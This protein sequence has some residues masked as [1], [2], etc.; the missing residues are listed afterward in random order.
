MEMWPSTRRTV[1]ECCHRT[2][3]RIMKRVHRLNQRAHT[4]QFIA[5]A[6]FICSLV[7]IGML[8]VE[9]YKADQSRIIA[10]EQ[11][12]RASA[13]MVRAWRQSGNQCVMCH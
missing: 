5:A 8:K 4:W 13:M 7:C 2:A 9:V 11:T 10:H 6:I 3:A 12:L 1:P